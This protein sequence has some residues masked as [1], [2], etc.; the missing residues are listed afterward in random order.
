MIHLHSGR[1]LSSQYAL[2]LLLLLLSLRLISAILNFH[3]HGLAE[4]TRKAD[5]A[6]QVI[7]SFG[8]LVIRH[9]GG[10]DA[11]SSTTVHH[12]R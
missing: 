12:D 10:C 2:L 5:A 6:R 11:C 8:V 1:W 3:D 9:G 4:L 7:H